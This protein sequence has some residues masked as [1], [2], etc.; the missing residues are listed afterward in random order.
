MPKH[1][2]HDYMISAQHRIEEAYARIKKHSSEDP[3]TAG[4]QGEEDW[5]KFLQEWLPGYFHIV[6]KGVILTDSGYSSPQIDLLV[7]NPSYPRLLLNEKRYLAG[8]VVAAFECKTTLRAEHIKKAVETSAEL[9]RHLP[10]RTGT[11]YKELNSTIVYG[12]LAHS[13][14]WTS[15][16]STPLD[17]IERALIEADLTYVKHP[18]ECIDL[19][20]V[21]DLATWTI[22]KDTYMSPKLPFYNQEFEKLYGKNG[23]ASTSYICSP[24]SSKVLNSELAWL[25]DQKEYFSPLGALVSE[26]YSKLAWTFSNMRSLDEY[27][28]KIDIH[29]RGQGQQA[30]LWDL[31][32]YSEQIRERVFNG[33]LSNGIPFDEWSIVFA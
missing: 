6:N 16:A 5:S 28:R 31:N 26:L 25:K 23:S 9:R 7:L 33:Q 11:P 27:F 32:I 24:I 4:D 30:R 10:K 15:E 3:G 29:G 13:H 19:I 21:S 1:D 20:T 18:I 12:L 17:N 8:G 14:S 2:I 22:F